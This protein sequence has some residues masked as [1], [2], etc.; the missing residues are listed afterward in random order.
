MAWNKGKETEVIQLL[1]TGLNG[2]PGDTI[3]TV[4]QGRHHEHTCTNAPSPPFVVKI[5]FACVQFW[6]ALGPK[7]C[8]YPFVPFPSGAKGYERG[9][10][11]FVPSLP[12]KGQ[13][14]VVHA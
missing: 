9:G 7:M 13:K 5:N 11:A 12:K 10:G 6:R 2:E 3:I 8:S 1:L 4:N 14:E